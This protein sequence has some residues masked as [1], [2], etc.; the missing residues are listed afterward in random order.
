MADE[1]QPMMEEGDE[2]KDMDMNIMESKSN[3]KSSETD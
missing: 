3:K 2:V 1:A